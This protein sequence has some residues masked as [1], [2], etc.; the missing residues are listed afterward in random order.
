MWSIFAFFS[1]NSF[2]FFAKTLVF[3]AYLLKFFN[4]SL[5]NLVAK[6]VNILQEFNEN[7]SKKVHTAKLDGSL[8]PLK[9]QF[10]NINKAKNEFL[11]DLVY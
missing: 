8:D 10:F 3:T 4:I 1:R 5:T 2:T 9:T 6:I 11:R 7:F